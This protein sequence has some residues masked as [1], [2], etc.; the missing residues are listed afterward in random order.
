MSTSSLRK[1]RLDANRPRDHTFRPGPVP[2]AQLSRR[3]HLLLWGLRVLA[4]L[5]TCMV[6]YAFAAQLTK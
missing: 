4:L 3:T 2:R 1:I 6:L 5:V